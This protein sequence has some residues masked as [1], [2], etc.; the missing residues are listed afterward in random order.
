MANKH[1]EKRLT[2][3]VIRKLKMKMILRSHLTPVRMTK[4]KNTG[5]NRCWQRCGER[6]TLLHCW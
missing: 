6:G 2:C 5:D 3:L 1:L 4:I